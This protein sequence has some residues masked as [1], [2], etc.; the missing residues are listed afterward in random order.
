ME[1]NHLIFIDFIL[2]RK[3]KLLSQ[4]TL[5]FYH[6]TAGK[7]IEWCKDEP[8]SRKVIA[9]LVELKERDL[10]PHSIHAHARG[11]RAFL[12]FAAEE[13]Y[14]PPIKFEM[15]KVSE[16]L[17]EILKPEEVKRILRA[18]LNPRDRLIILLLLDTGLRRGEFL[19]LRWDDIDLDT[20]KIIVRHSKSRRFRI[21]RVGLNTRRI[22][23]KHRR[24]STG[25]ELITLKASGLRQVFRRLSERSGIKCTPHTLRRTF[26][27]WSL[28]NG[29]PELALQSLLG[30]ADLSTTR[31][32]VD[33]SMV[34]VVSVVDQLY[35]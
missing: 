19:R 24:T 10:R 32:Y 1:N 23:L 33:L 2:S 6:N 11:I 18:C 7:F 28:A 31:R 22:L 34:E 16:T 13:G 26:A 3:A 30:H 12:N 15:P 14:L 35:R 20:G 5:E 17:P 4:S 21:V 9:Y 25:S 29:T 8:T 27:T